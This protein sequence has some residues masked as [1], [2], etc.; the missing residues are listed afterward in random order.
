MAPP[1]AE[2]GP[3][4]GPSLGDR[5]RELRLSRGLTQE[6]LAATRFSKEYLSQIERGRARPTSATIAWLARRLGADADY[7]EHGIGAKLDLVLRAEEQLE[8]HEYAAV[9]DALAGSVLPDSLELRARLAESWARMYL[10]EIEQALA[11]LERARALAGDEE[12]ANVLYRI[13]C[14]EYKRARIDEAEALFTEA[15]ALAE[16]VGAPDRLRAHVHE[17]RSRCYRRRR[18]WAAAGEDVERALELATHADG[19][20]HAHALFQASLVADRKGQLGRAR[21]LAKEAWAIYDELGDR[22]NAGRLLNNLGV[23]EHQLGNTERAE[24]CL[25]EA[26]ALALELGNDADA[27]QAVSSL[28][29]VLLDGGRYDEVTKHARHALELLRGRVD[30]LDEL[31]NAQIVLGRAL[32]ELGEL[33][34]AEASFAGAEA[35]FSGLAS[36][37]HAAAAWTAQGDLALRRGDDRAAVDRYRQAALALHEDDLIGREVI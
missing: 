22:Q 17:W 2:T 14:C 24:E 36:S 28:A 21:R 11:L 33:D 3:V 9:C 18:D 30:Y 27:A 8:R 12:L 34:E 13:G 25:Q 31:G 26:F 23:F 4:A 15:L 20:T 37:S 1:T 29:R 10:G 19:E 35:A 6:E 32:L 7:L 5:V 16:R